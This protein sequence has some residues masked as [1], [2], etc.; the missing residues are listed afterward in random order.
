MYGEIWLQYGLLLAHENE[1]ENE[2]E[3]EKLDVEKNNKHKLAE[4]KNNDLISALRQTEIFRDTAIKAIEKS[5]KEHGAEV[6]SSL[7]KLFTNYV[8]NSRYIIK[9]HRNTNLTTFLI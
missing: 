3:G 4:N 2:D 7:D 1:N 8:V 9:I 5:K 6:V